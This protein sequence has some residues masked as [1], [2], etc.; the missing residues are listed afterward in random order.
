MV[1]KNPAFVTGIDANETMDIV[2]ELRAKGLVQGKDFDFKYQQRSFDF[3]SS[4]VE[5]PK[6]ATFYFRAA[7]W[8]TFFRIKYGAD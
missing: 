2:R 6:G 7:K 8:A 3:L 5:K 1:N 4:E